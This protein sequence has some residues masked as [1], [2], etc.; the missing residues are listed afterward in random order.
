MK[1]INSEGSRNRKKLVFKLSTPTPNKKINEKD[2]S[3]AALSTSTVPSPRS[4]ASNLSI[5]TP[6]SFIPVNSNQTHN[7]NQTQSITESI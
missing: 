7:S 4:L 3:K 5:V 1:R 6:C 2:C